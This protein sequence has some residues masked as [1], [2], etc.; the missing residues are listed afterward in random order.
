[1]LPTWAIALIIIGILIVTFFLLGILFYS[2]SKKAKKNYI[3][4]LKKMK[5]YE[6]DRGKKLISAL[7]KLE[8]K[9]YKFDPKADELI[10]KG[11]KDYLS[12]TPE[13]MAMY[14]NTVDFTSMFLA[15]VHREDRRY[16]SAFS[17][18]ISKELDDMRNT[19][20][21]A[22]K[23]YNKAAANY[24]SLTNMVFTKAIMFIKKEKRDSAPIA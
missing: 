23:N 10:K 12:L 14:K 11:A 9:G 18:D 3:E 2:L 13:Q 6:E 1:M 20:T 16:S 7:D 8:A 17:D 22:Y 4:E 19:S 21:E 24:N 5:A 15:K